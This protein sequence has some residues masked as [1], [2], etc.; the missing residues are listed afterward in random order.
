MSGT[1]RTRG[2]TEKPSEAKTSRAAQFLSKG[3]WAGVAGIAGVIAIAGAVAAVIA[4]VPSGQHTTQST[5]HSSILDEQNMVSS[6]IAG[7]TYAKLQ[8]IIAMPPDKQMTLKSGRTLYQ[9]DRPWEYIDLL[10]ENGNVLSVGVYAKTAT[11]RATLD[12][13]GYH[14]I[15]NG[16]PIARQALGMGG[17]VGICGGNIGGY[18]FEGF[19]L[20]QVDQQASVAL[21]WANSG[22]ISVP[23]PACEAV[24]DLS[25]S[26]LYRCFKLQNL[27]GYPS[28]RFLNCLNGSKV[29]Q[30]IN[31]LSPAAVVVTAS[32]QG[33]VP[34]MLGIIPVDFI[35]LG[36]SG[37]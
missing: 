2:R 3:W 5:S 16:P 12:A 27:N 18:F 9:F 29:G 6:L 28:S 31:Q 11:F 7:D 33:I 36:P 8:D 35:F 22:Q 32:A 34:D 13:G 26:P 21:G 17:A 23:L 30:S 24:D 37:L 25:Q 20:P 15:L 4:I 10:V 14:V 1:R 19:S